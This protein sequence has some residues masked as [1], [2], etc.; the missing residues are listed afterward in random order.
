M[1]LVWRGP[2]GYHSHRNHYKRKKSKSRDLVRILSLSGITK[3]KA[4][5]ISGIFSEGHKRICN[6]LRMARMRNNTKSQ[7][8]GHKGWSNRILTSYSAVGTWMRNTCVCRQVK[9]ASNAVECQLSEK[10]ENQDDGSWQP[11]NLREIPQLRNMN[12]N[13]LENC[14]QNP[15]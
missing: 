10:C 1:F 3:A 8:C 13:V 7:Y 11:S 2:L 12:P 5:K 9:D 15:H 4:K 14:S 6:G